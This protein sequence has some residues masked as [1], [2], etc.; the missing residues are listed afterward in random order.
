MNELASLGT[1]LLVA[2]LAGHVVKFLRVP[3]VTGYI[4]AGVLLGPTGAHLITHE[5]LDSLEVFSEVALGLILFAIGAVFELGQFR[6]IGRQVA[7]LTATESLLAALFVGG[8]A[9]AI[10]QPLIIALLLGVIA[11]ETAAASTLMVM[12]ECNAQ[13]PLTETLSALIALNNIFCLTGF[14][15]LVA[16]IDLQRQVAEQGLPRAVV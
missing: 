7:T 2:L 3:E 15:A 6:R 10:G 8:G 11:M 5:A 4:L 9:L 1:I 14:L 12:R 16:G 13:G